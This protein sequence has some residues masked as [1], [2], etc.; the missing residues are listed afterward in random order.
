[1]AAGRDSP[2]QPW[3]TATPSTALQHRAFHTMSK[4]GGLAHDWQHGVTVPDLPWNREG[5]AGLHGDLAY[6]FFTPQGVPELRGRADA[7]DERVI[8]G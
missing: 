3:G 1:M 5:A 8:L 7:V 4:V 2:R 6:E